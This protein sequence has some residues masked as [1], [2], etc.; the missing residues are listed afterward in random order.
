MT[1]KHTL[2]LCIDPTSNLDIGLHF[3][4][5]LLC[6]SFLV[7][8]SYVG[9]QFF[10]FFLFI[11]FFLLYLFFKTDWIKGIDRLRKEKDSASHPLLSS[12]T[13]SIEFAEN[14]YFSFLVDLHNFDHVLE[15]ACVCVRASIYVTRIWW[16]LD[17]E[18]KYNIN[19]G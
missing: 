12:I 15:N 6:F 5:V 3:D 7:K 1:S 17:D 2:L 18:L 14:F 19:M 16:L 8:N 4:R 10:F 11:Y 9:C 13:I